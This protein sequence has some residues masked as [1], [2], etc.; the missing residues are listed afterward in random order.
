MPP[1]F[2]KSDGQYKARVCRLSKFGKM[3]F[4]RF[5]PKSPAKSSLQVKFP[6]LSNSPLYS[7]FPSTEYQVLQPCKWP[8]FAVRISI[9]SLTAQKHNSRFRQ[10]LRKKLTNCTTDQSEWAYDP[11]SLYSRYI[12]LV[13]GNRMTPDRWIERNRDAI[14]A[15]PEQGF[16]RSIIRAGRPQPILTYLPAGFEPK[17]EYPLIVFLHGQGASEKQLKYWITQLSRRNY[18][19]VSLRAPFEL[20]RPDGQVG[21]GWDSV[22]IEDSDIEDCVFNSIGHVVDRYPVHLGKVFLAGIGRGA[23]WSYR[24]GLTMPEK[25]AGIVGLDGKVPASTGSLFRL[26]AARKLPVF[27]AYNEHHPKPQLEEAR[28]ASRLLYTAGV[29]VTFQ[30]HKSNG[31]LP[32]E[33]MRDINRWAMRVV[34]E[35]Q[36]V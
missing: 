2:V 18:I 24:L 17:Y 14:T 23:S 19:A 33:L 1:A 31:T 11:Q 29:D 25:F 4:F 6:P 15:R 9:L 16:Y 32:A 21:F 20:N 7:E 3:E 8:I 27:M 30:V 34:T 22:N 5:S 35:G 10:P 12:P 28:K 26:P 36:P 13:K